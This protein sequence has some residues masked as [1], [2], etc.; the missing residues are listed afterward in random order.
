MVEN[1][2][3]ITEMSH[4][5][6]K[7]FQEMLTSSLRSAAIDEEMESYGKHQ[8]YHHVPVGDAWAATGKASNA[9]R[10]VDIGKGDTAN[11]LYR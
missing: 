1:C 6:E 3:G 8:V 10:W 7:M 2:T 11:P 4:L 5:L 9:V